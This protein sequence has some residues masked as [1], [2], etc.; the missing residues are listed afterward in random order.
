M[1]LLSVVIPTKDRMVFLRSSLASLRLI[2]HPGIEILVRDQSRTADLGAVAEILAGDPR[3][4]YVHDPEVKNH[5]E[6]FDRAVAMARG[7]Y[8]VMIGDDDGVTPAILPIVQWA[9]REGIE[10]VHHTMK[11]NYYWPDVV[12]GH[13][14]DQI[15]GTLIKDAFTGAV[16]V[17]DIPGEFER[18]RRNLGK[19]ML[20]LPRLYHGIV[21]R[22]AL[23]AIRADHGS[24]FCGVSPDVSSAVLIA[25]HIRKAAL[26]DFPFTIPGACNTSSS[27]RGASGKHYGELRR[28]PHMRGYEDLAWPPGIPE[29]FSVET[30][31]AESAVEAMR[32]LGGE[33]AVG[34][35]DLAALNAYY[36]VRHPG[37]FGP[38]RR[39]LGDLARSGDGRAAVWSGFLAGCIRESGLRLGYLLAR[40]WAIRGQRA[41][42]AM[43]LR[44]IRDCVEAVARSHPAPDL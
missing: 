16:R 5:V 40:A 13:W 12:S 14:G 32:S 20:G 35:L 6:H 4:T 25:H 37:D 26:I 41:T 38:V 1:P 23:D 30:V 3:I 27:G 22:S 15:Q 39:A 34:K 28:D 36:L 18:F 11:I 43:G 21:K 17:I 10:A 44:T 33:E 8:V 31:W 7:D 29:R 24:C 2:D 42:H 9:A 19:G